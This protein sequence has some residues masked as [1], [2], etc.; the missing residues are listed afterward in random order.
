MLNLA[1]P[2]NPIHEW[3]KKNRWANN[4][5]FKTL[6]GWYPNRKEGGR[7]SGYGN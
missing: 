5:F 1:S 6:M 7:F 3:E 4:P 2:I